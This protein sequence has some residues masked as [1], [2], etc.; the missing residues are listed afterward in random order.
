VSFTQLTSLSSFTNKLSR[1]PSLKTSTRKQAPYPME[2]TLPS[3]PSWLSVL[4]SP[5]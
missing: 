4:S 1:S 5:S 2:R 3:L